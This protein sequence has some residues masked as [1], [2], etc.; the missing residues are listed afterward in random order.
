VAQRVVA[1]GFDLNWSKYHADVDRLGIY[2]RMMD[3]IAQLPGVLSAAASNSFPLDPQSIEN[4]PS[5][6][7]FLIEGETRAQAETTPVA[8][9]R[10]VSP[11]Y[12]RTLG[13]PSIGGRTFR[14]DDNQGA[15]RVAVIS[16]S[17][18]RQRW[19]S[20]DPAGRRVTFND[21]K[22]WTRII[23]VVGDVK[24]TSLAQPAPEQILRARGAGALHRLVAGAH[25]GRFQ[26]GGR[27]GAPSHPPVGPAGGNH[28]RED[29]GRGA[30][31]C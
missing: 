24:E 14:E 31:R 23:G 30:N 26:T 20:Q 11:G 8:S 19:G 10:I 22:T 16:R 18:A 3:K 4:G 6:Q 1:V 21:G 28:V 9:M 7:T 12:F 17:L 15:E 2:R 13:I 27:A 25:R 5:L 29:S